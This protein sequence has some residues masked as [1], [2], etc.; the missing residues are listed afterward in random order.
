MKITIR[1]VTLKWQPTT[2][3]ANRLHTSIRLELGR[4]DEQE[5]AVEA[6][7]ARHGLE[8]GQIAGDQR[9]HSARTRGSSRALHGH[10]RPDQCA[11]VSLEVA[12]LLR[13]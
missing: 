9:L 5:G 11:Q 13:I 7:E 3:A 4:V 12:R 8:V 1:F 6:R 2:A 10:G